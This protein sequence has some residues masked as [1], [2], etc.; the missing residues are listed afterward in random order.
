[1]SSARVLLSF[2]AS[3]SPVVVLGEPRPCASNTVQIEERSRMMKMYCILVLFPSIL[4][5][6]GVDD[7]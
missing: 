7:A 2:F 5:H 1:M 4:F 6:Q 3:E